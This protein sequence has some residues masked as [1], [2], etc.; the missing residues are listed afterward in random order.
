[1]ALRQ[2]LLAVQN[3]LETERDRSHIALSEVKTLETALKRLH[4]P[5]QNASKPV[6]QPAYIS[7]RRLD[8]FRDKPQKLTDLSVEE[9]VADARA[10]LASHHM[11][12]KQQ[13]SVLL[14]HLGGKARQEIEGHEEDVTENPSEILDILLR[15]FGDVKSLSDLVSEFHKYKQKP[16]EDILDCSFELL[17]MFKRIEQLDPVMKQNKNQVLKER[18]TGAVTDEE[19]AREMRRLNREFPDLTFFVMRDDIIHWL[20]N[21]GNKKADPKKTN[22]TVQQMPADVNPNFTLLKEQGELLREQSKMLKEVVKDVQSLKK[23]KEEED[24]KK[25]ST[26]RFCTYCKKQN[27]MLKN[28]FKRKRDLAEQNGASGDK[29]PGLKN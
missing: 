18:L 4:I 20:G 15:V 8:K 24:Q 5:D 3:Q 13:A 9:W 23:W 16:E 21:A 25:G 11:N 17:K 28:C 12:Q 19:V 27:H 10:H 22:K 29:E 6:I 26:S 14:E 7:T 2:E 1:M